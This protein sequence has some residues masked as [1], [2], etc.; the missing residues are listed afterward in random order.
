MLLF[1]HTSP[2]DVQ[3]NMLQIVIVDIKDCKIT[4]MVSS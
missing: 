3:K 4:V 2:I 1:F